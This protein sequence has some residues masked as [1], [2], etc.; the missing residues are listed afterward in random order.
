MSAIDQESKIDAR[1][2][3]SAVPFLAV[4]KDNGKRGCGMLISKA[5]ITVPATSVAKGG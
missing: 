2:D 5:E 1:I 4:R 3:S